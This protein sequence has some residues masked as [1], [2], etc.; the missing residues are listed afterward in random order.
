MIDIMDFTP[1]RRS[2]ELEN[3]SCKERKRAGMAYKT[4]LLY[5]DG[6]KRDDM[7]LD[8]AIELAA[9]DQAH[10]IALRNIPRL[11]HP[12]LGAY[13][14]GAVAAIADAE[15][16]YFDNAEEDAKRLRENIERRV[17]QAGISF[18]WRL[19]KNFAEDIV[20][21]HARY[22]D[23]TIMGQTDPEPDAGDATPE[24]GRAHV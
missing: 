17:E 7:R 14:I 8:I 22:A 5:L 18:E 12:A 4:I 11:A 15:R 1:G 2:L 9:F 6:G 3:T 16:D 20:P 13:A 19:E 24:I 10:L 21:V 23:L